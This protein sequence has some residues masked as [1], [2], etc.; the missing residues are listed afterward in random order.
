M[1]LESL[2]ILQS[3]LRFLTLLDC[4][5]MKTIIYL[6]TLFESQILPGLRCFSNSHLTPE[7]NRTLREEQEQERKLFI[8]LGLLRLF[9]GQKT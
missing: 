7:V 1:K 4:E 3:N 9:D 6:I 8:H 2:S 5:D